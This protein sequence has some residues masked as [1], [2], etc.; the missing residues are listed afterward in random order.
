MQRRGPC[1]RRQTSD[2]RRIHGQRRAR[3]GGIARLPARALLREQGRGGRHSAGRA[4]QGVSL[5]ADVQGPGA[6]PFVALQDSS[7]HIP[8]PQGE[9]EGDGEHRG[10]AHQDLYLALRT[11]PPKERSSITLYY[12]SGYNIEEIAKITDATE[13]A[14]KKQMSR[15]REKLKERLRL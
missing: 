1:K 13:D 5:V 7:Q 4:S 11:L 12:L 15:G 2:T 6:I 9:R 3:A 10:G 8:Q 14:V